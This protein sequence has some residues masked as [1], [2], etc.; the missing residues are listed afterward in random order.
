[1]NNLNNAISK[2]R[3]AILMPPSARIESMKDRKTPTWVTGQILVD[4]DGRILCSVPLMV[5]GKMFTLR[6]IREDGPVVCGFM[7]KADETASL[8]ELV[9]S[10]R[11][12]PESDEE[13]DAAESEEE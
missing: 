2:L 10:L 9:K 4:T 11:G 5:D 7:S 1:M 13:K 3:S 8:D 12:E 6:V